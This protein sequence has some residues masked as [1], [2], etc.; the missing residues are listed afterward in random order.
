M[1]GNAKKIRGGKGR[2]EIIELG[3]DWEP[4]GYGGRKNFRDSDKGLSE[5]KL[6]ANRGHDAKGKKDWKMQLWK[7]GHS[8]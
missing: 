7:R 8:A 4:G 5:Q 6:R 1:G 3:G 2:F